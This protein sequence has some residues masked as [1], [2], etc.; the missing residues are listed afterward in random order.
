MSGEFIN[1]LLNEIRN[2]AAN[3]RTMEVDTFGRAMLDIRSL[4]LLFLR[5]GNDIGI[6]INE[7]NT[8]NAKIA[9]YEAMKDNEKNS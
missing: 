1:N 2:H 4:E 7:I 3:F 9:N 5:A 6:L 8:L